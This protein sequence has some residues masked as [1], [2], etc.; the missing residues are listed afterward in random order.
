MIILGDQEQENNTI[1]I[2]FRNGKTVQSLSVDQLITK[3][4][5]EV[6]NRKDDEEI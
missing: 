1:S 4:T 5:R 6:K 2:R 3:L